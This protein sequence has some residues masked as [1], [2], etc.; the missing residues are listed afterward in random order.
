MR[1]SAS[2][3]RVAAPLSTGGL[4]GFFC[5]QKR[6]SR[7][8]EGMGSRDGHDFIVDWGLGAERSPTRCGWVE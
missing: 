1:L 7:P 2:T 4:S 8:P 6:V 3:D 5:A